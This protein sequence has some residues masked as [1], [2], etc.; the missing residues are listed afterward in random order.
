M[1]AKTAWKENQRWCMMR[2]IIA[3][4]GRIAVDVYLFKLYKHMFDVKKL[5]SK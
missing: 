1:Y 4:L 2:I 3:V 5:F